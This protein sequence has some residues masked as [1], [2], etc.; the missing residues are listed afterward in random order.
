MDIYYGCIRAKPDA[1]TL[2]SLSARVR[3]I[4]RRPRPGQPLRDSDEPVVAQLA[5]ELLADFFRAAH[6]Q[7]YIVR[8]DV[9]KAR[10]ATEPWPRWCELPAQLL[11]LLNALVSPGRDGG[12]P[13]AYPISVW[14]V[15]IAS[16]KGEALI[17][18][19]RSLP[20]DGAILDE[21]FKA[22]VFRIALFDAFFDL[23]APLALDASICEWMRT[24]AEAHPEIPI[25]WNR[26]DS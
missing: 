26:E 3:R 4:G 9:A 17:E 2:F 23:L 15:P 10:A 7:D 5:K 21:L 19:F 12:E 14:F 20:T 24:A 22:N 1:E 11:G 18:L 16:P 25:E 8:V 13:S 6:A